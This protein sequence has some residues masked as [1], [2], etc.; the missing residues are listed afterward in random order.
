MSGT[1]CVQ[2]SSRNNVVNLCQ[3]I[4]FAQV[5]T[6]EKFLNYDWDPE[7]F[8]A[9]LLTFPLDFRILVDNIKLALNHDSNIATVK[10]AHMTAGNTR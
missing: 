2:E 4:A 9:F 7:L 5:K 3:F 6:W 8:S 10:S 1:V